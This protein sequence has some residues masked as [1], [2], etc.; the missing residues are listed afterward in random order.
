M[1]S[2]KPDVAAFEKIEND[3]LAAAQRAINQLIAVKDTRTIENTLAPFDEAT[4]QLNA[5]N[6]FA[7]VMERVHPA[8]AFRDHASAMVRKASAAQTALLLNSDVYQAL[9]GLDVTRADT[10]TR[11]YVQ[12][13]LLEFRLA[14]V[15]KDKNTRTRL[16]KLNDQLTSAESMFE[17]NITDDEKSIDVADASELDG[18]PP[19]FIEN[20]RPGMDGKIRITTNESEYFTVMKYAKSEALRRRLWVAFA[21][22]AYPQ[23]RDV[24]KSMMQARYEIARVLGY[25]S[26]ADYN[27]ADEMV[28]HGSKIADFIREVDAAARPVMQREIAIMVS[29]KQKTHP[30]AKE[31]WDFDGG[32]YFGGYYV[33]RVR[34]SKYNFDSQAVRPYFPYAR[35][36]QGVLD[37][38]A[39]LFHVSFRQ[40]L[41]APSWESS[42]E[43]WDVLDSGK[44]IGRFY[45]DM[46]PRPGKS[47]G[48]GMQ[49][50]LDGIRGKQFPEAILICNYPAPTATDPALMDYRLVVDFFHEFGHIMHHILGGQQQWAGNSG[51]INVEPDFIEVPSQLMEEWVGSPQVLASFARHYKT[52]EP[53][54]ADLV[55]RMNRA[56]AFGRATAVADENA[57][58]AVSYHIYERRPDEVDLHSVCL[59]DR[60]RFTLFRITPESSNFY[61]NFSHLAGYSSAFY[62]Y[63]WDRVIAVD[64]F[65]D[66]DRKNLLAGDAPLRYRHLVLEPGGSMSANDLVKNFLGRPTNLAA[67]QRWV[68][69]EF[70]PLPTTSK[71]RAQ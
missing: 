18:L 17:R 14:G 8:A 22:R 60:R 21:T 45:L 42:V 35:V 4:Q 39:A 52:G 31:L 19:D 1:W 68:G 36:K 12:R 43:T 37:T 67:F 34:R 61:A 9:A 15:N 47:S 59:H 53:I 26:W 46:H 50:V 49:Q 56:S 11:Y 44:M 64:L 10:A 27:A 7:T 25:S 54:P 29:E 38:A 58:A 16:K 51:L 13:Q 40:E 48:S 33:E 3:R 41:D 30:Q 57:K 71:P 2:A 62:T 69:E 24:L 28:L 66:F 70:D 6:Y 5:A 23:N 63:L 32:Y 65:Q 55:A 20:H